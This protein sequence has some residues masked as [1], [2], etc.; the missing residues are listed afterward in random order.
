[1][2]RPHRLPR[3]V[4]ADVHAPQQTAISSR[5]RLL[6]S[7][8]QHQRGRGGGRRRGGVSGTGG[9]RSGRARGGGRGG[10]G[11]FGSSAR[12]NLQ[13][14]SRILYFKGCWDSSRKEMI[15]VRHHLV[16][17][18]V[19]PACDHDFAAKGRSREGDRTRSHQL[20]IFDSCVEANA[21]RLDP[22]RLSPD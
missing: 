6:R 11:L 5:A 22:Y 3:H 18:Y 16:L 9:R 7:R 1:M 21:H 12:A 4:P 14:G 8:E 19:A 20:Q 2:W 15:H 10:S 13:L 17:C